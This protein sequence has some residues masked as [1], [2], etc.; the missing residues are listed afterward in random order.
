MSTLTTN[1]QDNHDPHW[2]ILMIVLTLILFLIAIKSES[3]ICSDY[4]IKKELIYEAKTISNETI[5][6]GSCASPDG[7]DHSVTSTPPNYTWL[8]T[9]GYCYAITPTRN[10]TVC[11]TYIAT[12]DSVNFNAGYSSNGCAIVSFNNFNLYKCSPSCILVGSGLNFGGLIPGQCY[13][14]CF[15]GHCIGGPGP[16]FSSICPY[17]QEFTSVLPIQLLS[18]D[19][20]G[21][22]DNIEIEWVTSNEINCKEYILEKSINGVDFKDYIHIPSKNIPKTH[23]YS[24]IDYFNEPGILTYYRLTQVDYNSN[25]Q[26]FNIIACEYEGKPIE[27]QYFNLLGEEINEPKGVYITKLKN[28]ENIRFIKGVNI[29]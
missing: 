1:K 12:S 26:V 8:N 17:Y 7:A 19:C 29:Q 11:Y 18:F 14:W 6:S 10:F 27:K 24:F 13:T 4:R 16:G 2:V 25:K 28:G 5:E 9:N 22:I 20:F 3:Q 23:L 15:S 21:N